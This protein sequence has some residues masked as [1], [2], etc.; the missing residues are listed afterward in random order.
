[1]LY[2]T[3]CQVSQIMGWPEPKHQTDSNKQ[4][5]PV[6]LPSWLSDCINTELCNQG[7]QSN[8]HHHPV[9]ILQTKV[10]SSGFLELPIVSTEHDCLSGK[11]AG[12]YMTLGKSAWQAC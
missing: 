6:T 4:L 10:F 12:H 5:H 11:L 1:M 9:D 2:D 8:Y 3:A 7:L